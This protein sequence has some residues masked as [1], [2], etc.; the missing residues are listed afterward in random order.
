MEHHH[1]VWNE[2][3]TVA[4][5]SIGGA[6]VITGMKIVVGIMTGSL[7]ILAEAAHSGL[8]FVA[9]LITFAAVKISD[10]PADKSHRYGHGK[11]ENISALAETLLLLVTCAWIIYE[12]VERLTGKSVQVD[13]GIWSFIVMAVSIVVDYSR[14]RALYRVAKKYNSQALEADALHFKTDIWSSSVVILGLVLTYF[15]A[16]IADSAAALVVAVIVVFVSLELGKRTIDDLV[17]KAPRGMEE[18]VERI[19]TAVPG[20]HRTD[21]VRVRSVGA[22]KFIDLTVQIARTLPFAI[23]HD[24]VHSA[25]LALQKVYPDTDIIIHP[26][27][28]ETLDETIIDKVKLLLS[29]ERLTAH[30]VQVFEVHGRYQI[31]FQLEFVP[32]EKFVHAHERVSRLE[33]MIK[34]QIPNVQTV[35]IHIEDSRENVVVSND[36]TASAQKLSRQLIAVAM[37]DAELIDCQV[38]SVLESNGEYRVSLACTVDNRHSLEHVHEI[39][40]MIENRIRVEFPFIKEVTIH[41]EP[42]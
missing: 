22:K 7:G 13:V 21:K 15:K 29:R 20:V 16:P 5:S 3:T 32:D 25:E 33:A 23:A 35:I 26:E 42:N 40:T 17:D 27:P 36:V 14:S 24:L 34:E 38:L 18:E 11:V 19:V 41:A 4:L 31:E 1:A 8:D 30:D 39:S 10:R 2:K 12:A 37:T 6:V 9:A 28:V